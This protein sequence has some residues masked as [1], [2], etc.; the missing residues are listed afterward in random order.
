MACQ[1]WY[2]HEIGNV[3]YYALLVPEMEGREAWFL[4]TFLEAYFKENSM[5]KEELEKIPSY[6]LYRALLVYAYI[7]KIWT[8]EQLTPRNKAYKE[9]LEN[10]ILLRR[11]ILGL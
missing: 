5:P 9:R 1:S 6:L 4:N 3:L 7:C 8:A 2:A 10:S 11:K